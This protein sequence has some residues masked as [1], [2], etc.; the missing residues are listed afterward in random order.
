M[1][2]LQRLALAMARGLS[3]VQLTGISLRRPGLPVSCPLR[4]RDTAAARADR[5]GQ[6]SRARCRCRHQRATS[7]GAEV[8]QWSG[9]AQFGRL[10]QTDAQGRYEFTEL[11][12]GRFS[13]NAGI[14][15]YVGLQYGQRRPYENGTPILLRDA[16]TA[17]SIDFALPRGSVITGRVTDENGYPLAQVQIQARRFRYSDRGQRSLV[18]VGSPDTTDDRGEFRLYGLMPGEY[19]VDAT[20]RSMANVIGASVNPNNPVDGFQPTFYPGR[21]MQRRHKQSPWPSDRRRRSN[22][23]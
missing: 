12:V 6:D 7:S 21:R 13:L 18:P 2:T 22:G 17:A 1:K 16:E 9:N 20:V 8:L 15:G 5:N 11:P 14:P 3:P 10:T 4:R 23:R 19:L